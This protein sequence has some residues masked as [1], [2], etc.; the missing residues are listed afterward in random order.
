MNL[1]L[2]GITCPWH[3]I[4]DFLF[5][6]PVKGPQARQRSE[7]ILPVMFDPIQTEIIK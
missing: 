3:Y 4:V 6:F 5:L 7:G 2:F 1:L